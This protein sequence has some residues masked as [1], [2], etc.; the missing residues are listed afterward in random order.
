VLI[1]EDNGTN[2]QIMTHRLK[3]WGIT[4]EAVTNARDALAMLT[5]S[6]SFDAA[7]VDL[8]LPDKD[9]LAFAEEIRAL[10]QCQTLP[11]LLLSSIRLRGDDPRPARAD[12][13][14]F[15]H[16]PIRPA[17]LLDALYRSMSIQLQREKKA[18]ALPALDANF[19]ARFPLRLLLADDN[20]IN[21]KV[22][23]SVLQ[24]LGYRADVANNG[25]E[26]LQALEQKPYDILLL[27]VQ[28]PEMDGLEA[29]RQICLRW[30]ETRRPRIIAMT[31][32]AFLGDREKCLEAGMDDYI[33]KPVRIGELQAALERWA[34]RVIK[35]PDT[36]FFT[37][38]GITTKLLDQALIA[39]LS[40]MAP[41]GNDS[42]LTEL[43]DLFLESA[44]QRIAQINQFLTDPQKMAFHAHALKSMSLNLGA[45]RIAELCQKLEEMAHSGNEESAARLSQELD[46]TFRLTQAELIPLREKTN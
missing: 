25:L 16:K 23:L 38:Q 6:P 28:M 18:P 46:R 2:R 39:E 1:V 40:E 19:A 43:I 34:G 41:A 14:V 3:Q 37:R 21:Q 5:N 44:P 32:N 10:P 22:G 12:I 30:P 24:K 33:S 20:P 4:V 8:Q 11:L 29:A 9:G 17:Q 26:V 13:S 27:D 36:S 31:G 42:M 15:V 7:V 35:K 45:N